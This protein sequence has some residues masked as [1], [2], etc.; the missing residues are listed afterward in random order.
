MKLDQIKLRAQ[1]L[2]NHK[3]DKINF[4]LIL[5]V[6]LFLIYSHLPVTTSFSSMPSL[7]SPTNGGSTPTTGGKPVTL[8]QLKEAGYNLGDQVIEVNGK[9]YEGNDGLSYLVSTLFNEPV[10]IKIKSKNGSVKSIRVK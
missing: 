5:A 1:H 3:L 8:V 4:C 7:S 9:K 10:N 6:I 2:W